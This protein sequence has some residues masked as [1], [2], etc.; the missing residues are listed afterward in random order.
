MRSACITCPGCGKDYESDDPIYEGPEHEAENYNCSVVEQQPGQ[1]KTS[2]AKYK[3]PAAGDLAKPPRPPRGPKPP[4]CQRGK[5][6]QFRII[7]YKEMQLYMKASQC[8][9]ELGTLS[10][11]Y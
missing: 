3:Q 2:E 4:D 5:G 11:R 8:L 9:Y 6:E 1:D 10:Q 7:L